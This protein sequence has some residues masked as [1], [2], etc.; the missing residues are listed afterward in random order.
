MYLPGIDS[1]SDIA[2]LCGEARNILKKL[3]G[4]AAWSTL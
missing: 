1:E 4:Q 2:L 3:G